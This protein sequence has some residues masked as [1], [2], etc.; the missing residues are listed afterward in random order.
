MFNTA[1]SITVRVNMANNSVSNTYYVENE[2]EVGGVG[3]SLILCNVSISGRIKLVNNSTKG[4]SGCGG[5]MYLHYCSMVINDIEED[6][7]DISMVSDTFNPGNVLLRSTYRRI[8]SITT[9]R[10]QQPHL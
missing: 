2:C 6:N 3:I 10:L 4:Q 7:V 5:G 1:V 8:G 9:H